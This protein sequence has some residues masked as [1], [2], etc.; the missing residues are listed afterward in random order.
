[1]V[2]DFEAIYNENFHSVYKYVLSL[3][4]NEALAEEITQETF[5]KAMESLDKFNGNCR[6]FVW[7]C[8]IAKNTYFTLYKKRKRLVSES[9]YDF[10]AHIASDFESEYLDKDTSKRLHL[11]LHEMTEPYKEVFSLRDR[12]SVV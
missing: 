6:I 1:M 7:L 8:Q 9:D 3:C 10:S 2:T 12:K 4:Q 11:L 5:Y